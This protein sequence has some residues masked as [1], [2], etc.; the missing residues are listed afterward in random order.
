MAR[1]RR[2]RRTSRRRSSRRRRSTRNPRYVVANRR[3]RRRSSKRRSSRRRRLRRNVF[4]ADLVK[5][6]VVPVLGATAGFMAARYLGNMVAMED[7]GTTDP[8][9][10]K[11]IAAAVGIPAVFAGARSMKGGMLAKNSGAIVLGMGLAAAEAYLRDT[12]MLGG[13]RA[14]AAL[15]NGNGNGNGV[16][17]LP[18]TAP[19][20][21]APGEM[22]D[23]VAPAAESAEESGDGLSAYYSQSMLGSLGDPADQAAVEA[24]MD[25]VE[26]VSTVIPTGWALP[27]TNFPQVR[28]VTERFAG[29]RGDRGHAG[30]IYA[31]HL[32]SGMMGG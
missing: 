13:G 29:S 3:R 15:T 4:G 30:G 32:F 5:T 12:P 9:T 6:V 18:G 10:G 2:S 14:A 21:M 11:L 28:R 22:V 1:R 19:L 27:A 26:P 16:A 20:D 24:T 17:P 25:R 8:K 31:R 7:W 23:V